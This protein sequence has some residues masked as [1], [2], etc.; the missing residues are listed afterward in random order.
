MIQLQYIL[1]QY[2]SFTDRKDE[3]RAPAKCTDIHSCL[4][5]AACNTNC[6]AIETSYK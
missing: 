3:Y 6:N 5:Q 2:S 1:E 4:Q